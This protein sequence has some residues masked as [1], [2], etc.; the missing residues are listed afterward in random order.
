MD[1]LSLKAAVA[2]AADLCPGAKITDAWQAGRS[3]IVLLPA[4]GKGLVLSVDPVRPGLFLLD[5]G[6]VPERTPSSF[7]DLLRAR[8]KGTTL[9]TVHLPEPGERVVA[10]TFAAAWPVKR[11]APLTIV[12]EVMGRRSNLVVL[13]EGR[14]LQPLRAVPK[15]KSPARP[16]VAGDPYV[17]PPPRQ[18]IPVERA[19]T[20]DGSL[21]VSSGT[22]GR[23]QDRIR[24]L[25]PY[26]ASQILARV[27]AGAR[28]VEPRTVPDGG[29]V[30]EVLR[31]ILASCNGRNGFLHRTGGRAHLCPFEPVPSSGSDSIERYAP[32]SGA[33]AAW[34]QS[35]TPDGAGEETGADRLER[36][37][38]E[39]LKRID[40]ALE[41]LDAEEERCRSHDDLRLMAEALLIGVSSVQAGSGRV[42]LPDPYDGVRTLTIDLDRSKS[43]QENANDL[44]NRA[45]RQKRGLEEVMVKRVKLGEEK[46]RVQEALEALTAGRD[47]GPAR[48]LLEGTTGLPVKKGKTG[49]PSYTGPGR[50]HMVGGFT[51]LVGKSSTDNEKVTFAAAGPNDLWLHARDYP[52]SHVVIL[53]GKKPVPDKVLYEAAALAAAGSGARNDTAPEI[54]VTERKWVR[55]LKGGKPGQVTVERFRTIRPRR[56]RDS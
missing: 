40:S 24:G 49:S 46:A 4:K 39:R 9:G 50:R 38:G 13:E 33:A 37:L 17:L 48:R 28:G 12:L 42:T 19:A 26:T 27:L 43:P 7:T 3:D 54:M 44:F 11:G 6:Q 34:R 35:G 10:L 36:A 5:R 41:R 31:E 25:S 47:M 2:E 51:V 18:G 53:K 16:L 20:D 1:Y 22:A 32:F 29:S 55:K 45:R 56:I 52:G 8:I 21:T 30:A 23:L 14:I 15:D